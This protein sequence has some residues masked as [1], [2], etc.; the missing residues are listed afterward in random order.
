MK[1]KICGITSL[2]EIEFLNKCDIDYIGFVF[3]KSKRKISIEEAEIL[4]KNTDTN[5]KTVGV[6]RNN[7]LDYVL[8]VLGKVKLDV[9]QLH[10]NENIEYIEKIREKNNIE[11]WKA[12]SGNKVLEIT[13]LMNYPVDKIL[14]DGSQPGSGKS[15]SWENLSKIN[16]TKPF[17]LAGGIDSDNVE[18]AIKITN[19]YGIDVSSKV[20]S[21]DTDGIRQK[22][23]QKI[24]KLIKKVR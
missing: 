16:I 5:I 12:A 9:V 2:K 23:V 19:P 6:F 10:G 17:F 18:E 15:F 20:E 21:I 8:E 11:I 7:T 13:E 4:T 1:I 22:D 3:A 14:L 24:K